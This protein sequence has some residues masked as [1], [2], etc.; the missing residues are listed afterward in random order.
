MASLAILLENRTDIFEV[1]DFLGGAQRQ[2]EQAQR[3]QRSRRKHEFGLRGSKAANEG[4]GEKI[5]IPDGEE[6]MQESR[7]RASVGFSPFEGG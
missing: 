5:I 2:C 6:K 1:A 4:K 7:R 3:D